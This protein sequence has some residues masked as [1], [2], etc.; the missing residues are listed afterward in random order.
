MFGMVCDH[1][2]EEPR[3]RVVEGI[4]FQAVYVTGGDTLRARLSQR[5][6]AR[7]LVCRGVREAAFLAQDV[8]R[9]VFTKRGVAPISA[10]PLYRATAAAIVR[11]YMTR[12]GLSP[13]DTTLAFAAKR[14]TPE[15][16]R[17]IESLSD[18]VRYLALRA[19]DGAALAGRLQRERG[20]V[21]RLCGE[22][23]PRADLTVVFDGAA[24]EKTML[25]LDD[26]LCVTFDSPYPNELL[27]ALWRAGA[28]DAGRL[29]VL[30]VST[31]E[32][33]EKSCKMP[34]FP[35]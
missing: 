33:Q 35:V 30:S 31:A 16:Y 26:M 27:A 25:R 15:L 18:D 17:A 28:L 8:D 6:A 12:K 13:R 34:T 20:V 11:R 32:S 29:P 24:E 1:G 23:S 7:A 14:M 10:A 2:G 21:V 22:G 3:E 4:R 9:A 19:S 5:A